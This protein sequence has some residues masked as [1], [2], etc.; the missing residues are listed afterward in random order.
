M[1]C[2]RAG[3]KVWAKGRI[4][5]WNTPKMGHR[6]GNRLLTGSD[7]WL[8][9]GL[10]IGL[11][12]E[13]GLGTDFGLGLAMVLGLKLGLLA[14]LGLGTDLVLGIALALGL[15]LGLLAELRLDQT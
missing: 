3:A 2:F 12:T 8:W 9:L 4:R 15:K 14:E 11:R 10:I 7:L 13:L 5:A 1:V 6:A